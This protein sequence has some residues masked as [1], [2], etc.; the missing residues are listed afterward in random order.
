M[1]SVSEAAIIELEQ[2][3]AQVCRRL[4]NRERALDALVGLLTMPA[5]AVW[6]PLPLRAF[7]S[8]LKPQAA[9][10]RTAPRWSWGG[11]PADG[12]GAAGGRAL[13][14]AR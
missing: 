7:P 8:R 9:A 4:G 12:E 14:L 13:S 3:S 11:D 1:H 5:F 6:A 2:R 10:P